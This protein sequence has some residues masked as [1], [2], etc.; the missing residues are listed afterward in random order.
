MSEEGRK[1]VR[2][3]TK[4]LSGRVSVQMYERVL[5]IVHQEDFADVTDYL[6]YLVRRDFEARDIVI[7]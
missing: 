7:E 6:R 2:W 4:I 5:D 3:K 1:R